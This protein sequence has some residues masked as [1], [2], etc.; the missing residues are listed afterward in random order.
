MPAAARSMARPPATEPVK[1]MWSIRP[2]PMSF[3][4]CSMRQ[5]EIVEET[6]G[7]AGAPER[8]GDTLADEQR[9]RGVLQ[10]DG[11]A[12]EKAGHD[13][14]DRGEIRIVPRRDHH[15]HADR[16]AR[17]VAAEAGLLRRVI[18]LER[19]L[20]ERR[21]GA[22]ALLDAA[23]LA[24]IADRPAHLPGELHGDVVVHRQERVEKGEHVTPALGTGTALHFGSAARARRHARLDIGIARNRALGIDR[25]VD[26]GDDLHTVGH[27]FFGETQDR[28][29]PRFNSQSVIRRSYSNCSHSA[30]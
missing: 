8:L 24:A 14:V 2:E 30:V 17:D 22:Y 13:S 9:L 28:S 16:L 29:K 27:W 12:G 5:D 18:G 15:H 20:G 10:D 11:I 21:H 26:G 3:S 23:L 4:V 7:Q 19:L 6:L 25:A 1:L